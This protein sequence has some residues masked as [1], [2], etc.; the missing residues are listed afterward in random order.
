MAQVLEAQ[1]DVFYP[2]TSGGP[3]LTVANQN[4]RSINTQ[5]GYN[6]SV[7]D[8]TLTLNGGV[9][10][11]TKF[12]QQLGQSDARQIDGGNRVDV[13]VV[14]E[15]TD[16]SGFTGPADA[17]NDDDNIIYTGLLDSP[18]Y[19]VN[20]DKTVDVT[21][22][23]SD[24]VFGIMQQRMATGQYRNQRAV[25][26][27]DAVINQLLR[28]NAPE[29]D[30]TPIQG[31]SSEASQ[32]TVTVNYN[33]KNLFE[34]IREIVARIG[35]KMTSDGVSFDIDF[36]TDLS[37]DLPL[38]PFMYHLPL[39]W[40]KSTEDLLNYVVGVGGSGTSVSSEFTTAS[41]SKASIEPNA[42]TTTIIGPIQTERAEIPR[43]AVEIEAAN[44]EV[45]VQVAV[46]PDGA[47][48]DDRTADYGTATIQ[49][50][51]IPSAAQGEFTT[52]TVDASGIN[53]SEIQLVVIPQNNS[54]VL[55][56]D[57]TDSD[58]T[59]ER[60]FY[61]IYKAFSA[62]AISRDRTSV[63]TYRKRDTRINPKV[64]TVDEVQEVAQAKLERSNTPTKTLTFSA[65][66]L[67]THTATTGRVFQV[68]NDVLDINAPYI[69]S[70][71]EQEYNANRLN[72]DLELVDVRSL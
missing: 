61:Q 59:P 16:L 42:G 28:R 67:V 23:G 40:E 31:L 1:L 30:R 11:D 65:A 55:F 41:G 21:V 46:Q 25:G 69:V 68:K 18:E 47:P 38:E 32:Q 51:S 2:F 49:N 63:D 5:K 34:A 26:D 12:T 4:I 57:D 24:F 9:E 33:R 50:E 20:G 60:F 64:N 17:L 39:S 58:G 44:N 37:P 48:P 54:I 62:A 6:D 19:T 71:V 22:S 29:I 70:Q 7:G 52:V 56:G 66:S 3:D 53:T 45:D 27:S 8:V 35:A 13:R 10:Q 36:K 15:Y 72:T 43:V 14:T